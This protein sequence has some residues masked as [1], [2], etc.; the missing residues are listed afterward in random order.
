MLFFVCFFKPRN[1][2]TLPVEEWMVAGLSLVASAMTCT[3]VLLSIIFV[4]RVP[5]SHS[6]SSLGK[7]GICT[8]LAG[9]SSNPTT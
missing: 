6:G 9:E 1:Q 7:V 5:L 3:S 4:R 2:S 8:V